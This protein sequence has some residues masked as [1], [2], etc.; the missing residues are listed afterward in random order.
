MNA[1]GIIPPIYERYHLNRLRYRDNYPLNN[2]VHPRQF[3]HRTHVSFES[4]LRTL[5]LVRF[6]LL[7]RKDLVAC[8]VS[9]YLALATG[10]WEVRS[11]ENLQAFVAYPRIEFDEEEMLQLYDRLCVHDGYWQRLLTTTAAPAHEIFYEDLLNQPIETMAQ[12]FKTLDIGNDPAQCV[13]AVPGRRQS[14][15]RPET[16]EFC[17]RLSGLVT[18]RG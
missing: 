15:H 16:R 2:K 18:Q 10:V 6:I 5:P 1:T 8:S 7:R 4:V 12:L 14:I 13:G 11:E 3:E 9:C 17:E